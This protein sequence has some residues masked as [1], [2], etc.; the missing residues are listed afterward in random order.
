[1]GY[2][3]DASSATGV[4][5]NAADTGAPGSGAVRIFR[6]SAGGW[7]LE[8]YVK[9]SNT[10]AFAHF[11]ASVALA[12]SI[13]VVGSPGESS[14]AIGVDANPLDTSAPGT[15]A[16]YVFVDRRP[17]WEQRNYIKPPAAGFTSFG[18]KVAV[19]DTYLGVSSRDEASSSPIVLQLYARAGVTWARETEIKPPGDG[20][21]VFSG[22]T[23]L[24]VGIPD[25]GQGEVSVYFRNDPRALWNRAH[26]LQPGYL[27]DS[28]SIPGR[29]GA[30]LASLTDTLIVGEP[31][32][33]T[34]GRV[35][36]C[37]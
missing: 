12:G 7:G 26:L 18:R 16:V 22:A 8:A 29:F 21:M 2:P 34:N 25:R 36:I 3:D 28:E 14:S 30:T 5:G 17:S 23:H 20:T 32:S 10:R 31:G 15:G 35:W 19:S 9:P 33:G 11:G 4:N 27:S 24:F 6:A 37:R 1:V 13:V